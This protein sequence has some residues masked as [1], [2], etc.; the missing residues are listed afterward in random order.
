MVLTSTS[1]PGEFPQLLS[2]LYTASLICCTKCGLMLKDFCVGF[3][4][5]VVL[6]SQL[7]PGRQLGHLGGTCPK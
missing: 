4:C 3:M 2:L 1:D 5:W 7:E 6:R